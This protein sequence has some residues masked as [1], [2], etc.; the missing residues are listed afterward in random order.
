MTVY[1]L[2]SSYL[3]VDSGDCEHMVDGVFET[4]EQAQKAMEQEIKDT[5][6]DFEGVDYEEDNYVEGDM[7]WSIWEKECYM[8]YH[9]DIKITEIEVQ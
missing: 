5:R 3:N 7:S 4:F 2:T 6:T 1:V 9:C 8:S